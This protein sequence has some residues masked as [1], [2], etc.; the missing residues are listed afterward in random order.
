MDRT[1]LD[2]GGLLEMDSLIKK[3]GMEMNIMG[4]DVNEEAREKV[5]EKLKVQAYDILNFAQPNE[6]VLSR[7]MFDTMVGM[8][9]LHAKKNK[10]YGK[11][12]DESLDQF[13]LTSYVIRAQD[14][15][16]RV[17]TLSRA[18]DTKPLVEDESVRD[19]LLDL[20]N[21]SIMAAMWLELQKK[22]DDISKEF[23][24]DTINKSDVVGEMV[25]QNNAEVDTVL[26]P[27][28]CNKGIFEGS[29]IESALAN[30]I[31]QE[32]LMAHGRLAEGINKKMNEQ[33]SLF[34]DVISDTG[35]D[36]M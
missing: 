20:A 17:D 27:D 5:R 18:M 21:Y 4:K 6:L 31:A 35:G 19:S 22:T 16:R 29:M 10:D 7:H 34:G 28:N 8:L 30:G 14:K 11:S 9:E 15:L 33:L 36:M 1:F 13:G 25:R 23:E 3:L 26:R 32:A 12:F 24:P 2:M